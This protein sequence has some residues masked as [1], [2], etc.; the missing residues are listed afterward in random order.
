[1]HLD[2]ARLVN[3]AV[4][5]GCPAARL[6]EGVDSVSLCLSKGL[7]APVGSMLAGSVEFIDSARR[8]RKTF[9]GGMRQAGILAAA[10]LIA[11]KDGPKLLARDHA[12]AQQIAETARSL[13]TIAVEPVAT[14]IVMLSFAQRDPA[15]LVAFLAGQGVL[16]STFPGGMVRFVTH[17]DLVDEDVERCCQA[18]EQWAKQASSK[19]S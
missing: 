1:V 9:G 13:P 16:A 7:G 14:N 18:L 3:A 19:S 6:A 10:G 17:R 5:C 15:D 4:A 8:V 12:R 2:G 11:L